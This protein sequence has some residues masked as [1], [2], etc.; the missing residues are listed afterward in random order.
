MDVIVVVDG[1]VEFHHRERVAAFESDIVLR[2]H[3]DLGGLRL[4]DDSF[5]LWVVYA[6]WI[7]GLLLLYPLCLWYGNLKQRNKHC[8]LSYLKYDC[9]MRV[10]PAVDLFKIHSLEEFGKSRVTTQRIE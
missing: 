1:F 8:L 5:P 9:Y 6:A 10:R 4:D 2:D 3:R 7:G